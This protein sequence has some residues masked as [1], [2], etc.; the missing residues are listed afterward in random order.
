MAALPFEYSYFN[1]ADFSRLRTERDWLSWKDL[2]HLEYLPPYQVVRHRLGDETLYLGNGVGMVPFRKREHEAL[3]AG[4]LT[5]RLL[6][7]A[8]K[9]G[10]NIVVLPSGNPQ[11]T[12]IYLFEFHKDEKLVSFRTE[13]QMADNQVAMAEPDTQLCGKCGQEIAD[14]SQAVL[15]G[16]CLVHMTSFR[17]EQMIVRVSSEFKP[18]SVWQKDGYDIEL[19]QAKGEKRTNPERARSWKVEIGKASKLISQLNNVCNAISV[20]DA[21]ITKQPDVLEADMKTGFD[22]VKKQMRE[23][24]EQ[25]T[26]LIATSAEKMLAEDPVALPVTVADAVTQIK[27][28][29][30][31]LK[32]VRSSYANEAKAKKA[33]ADVN[34]T[35]KAKAAPKAAKSKAAPGKGKR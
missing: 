8:N 6:R 1:E 10:D 5:V 19:L 2:Q 12:R 35:P 21:K 17:Q 22:E 20:C 13:A 25:A 15:K 34:K 18:L 4:V 28:S 32:D 29:Q 27:A 33:A 31:L 16:G 30:N 23:W 24:K 14:T 11:G 3:E 7:F 9:H 26:S